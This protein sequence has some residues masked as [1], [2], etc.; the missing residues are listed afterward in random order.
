M[1][2]KQYRSEYPGEFVITN[3]VF[4]NGKKEQE[5]VWIENPITNTSINNRACC[6]ASNHNNKIPMNR[7]E[8]HFGGN[9]SK[10]KMQLYAVEEMWEEI[11]AD[12]HIVLQQESLGDIKKANFQKDHIVYTLA[13]LCIANPGKFYLIPYSTSYV[14]PATTLWVACF[15]GHKEIYLYGYNWDDTAENAKLIAAVKTI[16]STYDDVS[17]Y[18]VTDGESPDQW[19][20][21][22]NL[23]TISIRTFVSEC[24]I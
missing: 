4:K 20:R 16:M 19:R 24:D 23:K 7:I 9:L 15:D 11:S 5:R 3:T 22:I 18:H 10:N 14:A 21:C 6:I 2:I 13:G 1:A 12:F 17:F 8:N